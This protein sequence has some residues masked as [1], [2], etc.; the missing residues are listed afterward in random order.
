M[1][2][3]EEAREILTRIGREDDFHGAMD[4]GLG[5]LD[6]EFEDYWQVVLED[7]RHAE[8]VSSLRGDDL[9][10]Y[11][12]HLAHLMQE[13][14]QALEEVGAF[15]IDDWG[16]KIVAGGYVLNEVR[17]WNSIIDSCREA[18]DEEEDE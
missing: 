14:K 2:A 11:M 15:Q 13:A 12:A 6:H 9:A 1:E 16:R 17:Y 5:L 4:V 8:R 7:A 18:A 10:N 3:R